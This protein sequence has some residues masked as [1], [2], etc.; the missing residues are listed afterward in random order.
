MEWRAGEEAW[1]GETQEASLLDSAPSDSSD[2]SGPVLAKPP[3]R[4]GGTAVGDF[5]GRFL[6][7]LSLRPPKLLGTS[8]RLL[9]CFR[10]ST[11][12]QSRKFKMG[13]RGGWIGPKGCDP[14]RRRRGHLFLRASAAAAPAKAVEKSSA[15]ATTAVWPSANNAGEKHGVLDRVEVPPRADH[16]SV[17][18]Q[19]GTLAHID[20]LPGAWE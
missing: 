17:A 12:H 5:G 13:R 20:E 8:A 3:S 10:T 16:A 2:D 7:H 15:D 4:L 14:A 9:I 19:L 1:R 11:K 18:L 6:L